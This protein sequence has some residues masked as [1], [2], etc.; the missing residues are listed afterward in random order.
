MNSK[1]Y[2]LTEAIKS[3]KSEIE[4]RSASAMTIGGEVHASSAPTHSFA[5]EKT[6]IGFDYCFEV[7]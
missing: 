7:S 1:V 3:T 2:N 5:V 6:H 4:D